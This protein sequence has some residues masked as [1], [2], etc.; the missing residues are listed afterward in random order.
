MTF[1]TTARKRFPYGMETA[2]SDICVTMANPFF[3]KYTN[4]CNKPIGRI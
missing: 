4:S 3:L 2:H 1:D